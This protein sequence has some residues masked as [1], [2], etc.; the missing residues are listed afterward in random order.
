MVPRADSTATSLAQAE[1]TTDAGS[2]PD[3]GG[4]GFLTAPV[5]AGGIVTRE[6]LSDEQREIGHTAK[7]F[8]ATEVMPRLDAIEHK[9]N[10]THAGVTQP[11][12]VHLLRQS[13]ELGLV[14]ADIPEAYGGLGLDKVTSM[15]IAE[16]SAGC[17]SF[18]VTSGAHCGIG[19][20]P[21]VLFGD[22]RQKQTYLPKLAS[23]ELVS[24]Y[25]LT[26]PGSGSDALSGKTR[27]ILDAAGTHY[28]LSGEKQ[29]ITN[30]SWADLAIVFAGVEGRYSAFIVDLHSP[31]V[32]RGREEKKMGIRGSSTTSLEFDSV[33]VPRENLLGKVGDGGA[34]ALNI[35]NLGR[36]KLGFGALGTCKVALD[37]GIAYGK[38]RKQFGQP[39]I[40][41]DVQRAKLGHLA[42]RIYA[43]DAMA[44]RTAGAI[45]AAEEHLAA[46]HAHGRATVD[47]VRAFALEAAILKVTGS[48]TLRDVID[49]ALKMHGGYG[50]IEEYHLERLS[51]D[52][53]ID[54]IFE[55]TND[56][57]RLVVADELV[58]NI[59]A[60]SIHFREFMNT[61]AAVLRQ[62]QPAPT[63]DGPLGPEIA[64]VLAAKRAVA[65]AVQE[66]I[67]G[68]GRGL[69]TEE[70]VAAGIADAMSALYGMD[71]TLAR[72]RMAGAGLLPTAIARLVVHDGCATVERLCH[73]VVT[74]VV[75]DG[76]QP[77]RLAELERLQAS[78][79]AVVDAMSLRRQIADALIEAGQYNL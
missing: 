65:F 58:R 3:V 16:C 66:A 28:L 60:G 31:G 38:A 41:F 22:E 43:V 19:T 75:R 18:S 42:A 59:Y 32:K 40:T 50:Y 67:I 55:G 37:L 79:S 11:I 44:Y 56:I 26:E 68:C 5:P 25:A 57:N 45:A 6:R 34:I 77:R 36:L 14:A 64:R 46:K 74:H 70:Q 24:C 48:E 51:R 52:N 21:I 35:L 17:P 1:S 13:A 73:E 12:S 23:A 72:V 53:V 69:K 30:G 29:F 39:I 4:G 2:R 78:Q 62:D 49:G 54:M 61:T 15:H 10:V 20:L 63:P 76:Q 47:L 9:E 27:A 71:S 8:I 33:R 7:Q